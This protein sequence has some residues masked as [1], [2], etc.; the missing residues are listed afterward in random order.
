MKGIVFLDI[1][2]TT[3]PYGK[4]VPEDSILNAMEVLLN[5]DW[6]ICISSGRCYGASVWVFEKLKDKLYFATQN[7]STIIYKDKIVTPPKAMDKEDLQQL[8]AYCKKNNFGLIPEGT[9]NV[10]NLG[11]VSDGVKT[12]LKNQGI[13]PICVSDICEITDL[14]GQVTVDHSGKPC[15]V[16]EINNIWKGKYLAAVCGPGIIDVSTS[17]KGIGVKTL[18]EALKADPASCHSF[19]DS[20]NDK[21]MLEAVGHPHVVAWAPEHMKSYGQVCFDIGQSLLEIANQNE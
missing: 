14:I 3:V 11:N 16:E 7:G 8:W 20:D 10:Y 15:P 6:A 21:T 9:F 1:D 2:G 18:C 17:N 13:S 5:S 12:I 4:S 19:G